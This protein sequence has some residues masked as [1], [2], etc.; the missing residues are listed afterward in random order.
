MWED[1]P[2]KAVLLEKQNRLS[3]VLGVNSKNQ[4][5]ATA[6]ARLQL[7][8]FSNQTDFSRPCPDEINH[9]RHIAFRL[10]CHENGLTDQCGFT[11]ALR[12]NLNGKSQADR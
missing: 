1:R 11:A 12:S 5:I 3:N 9:F 6:D 4:I 7:H 8:C 2:A 10:K